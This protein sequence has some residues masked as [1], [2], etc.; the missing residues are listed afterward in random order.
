[1][2]DIRARIKALDNYIEM[3]SQG[4]LIGLLKAIKA[5][6]CNLRVKSIAPWPYMTAR[7]VSTVS[8]RTNTQHA[9]RT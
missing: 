2:D 9:R 4:N 1:M 6:V 8:I 3:F 5:L 7:A